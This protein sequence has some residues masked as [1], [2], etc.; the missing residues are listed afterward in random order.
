MKNKGAKHDSGFSLIELIVVAAIMGILSVSLVLN[1]QQSERSQTA[2]KRAASV[3]V[4]EIRR[5][6]ALSVSSARFQ[7]DIPCGYG[8]HYESSTSAF[9]YFG[10][11]PSPSD[12]N[13]ICNDENK[14]F[15]TPPDKRYSEIKFLDPN[16]E[17]KSAFSDVF[18]EPPNPTVYLNNDPNLT[19][20]PLVITIGIVGKSCP[21]NCRTIQVF[22]SGRVEVQ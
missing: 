20:P 18:F 6:Q 9:I 11:K 21:A 4:A 1:F 13:D 15:T 2:L 5:A 14:N 8:V 7:G 19:L 17:F 16:L 22:T 3:V 12:P 10:S